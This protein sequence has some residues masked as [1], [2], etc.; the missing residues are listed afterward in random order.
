[1][2]VL[3]V[4]DNLDLL[5][6]MQ[7]VFE[8][9]GHRTHVDQTGEKVIEKIKSIKPDLVLLDVF[10]SQKD[11]RTICEC[12]KTNESLKETPVIL[13][14]AHSTVRESAIEAGADDFIPKP[15]DMHQL[16]DKVDKYSNA[17]VN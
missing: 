15:F 14:S 8:I 2:K 11:G 5:D 13:F 6:A 3:I 16:L 10:L 1:M 17:R 4:D 12:I 7:M 9:E